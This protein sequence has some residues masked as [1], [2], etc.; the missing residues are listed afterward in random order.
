[1]VDCVCGEGAGAHCRAAELWGGA[2]QVDIERGCTTDE[3]GYVQPT[4]NLSCE[5]R[6]RPNGQHMARLS[7]NAETYVWEFTT[8]TTAC[9]WLDAEQVNLGDELVADLKTENLID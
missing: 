8:H 6:K 5:I 4:H 2:E 1:V 9:E 7:T 3:Q